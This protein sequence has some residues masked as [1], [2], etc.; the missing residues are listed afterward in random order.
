MVPEPVA[1]MLT[2]D[3]LEMH[4]LGH[5]LRSTKL[6][7]AFQQSP[8]VN[9]LQVGDKHWPI[10]LASILMRCPHIHLSLTKNSYSQL[11]SAHLLH[12]YHLLS[13]LLNTNTNTGLLSPS[14][15]LYPSAQKPQ[16]CPFPYRTVTARFL[17]RCLVHLP[18]ALMAVSK[19][20]WAPKFL[21]LCWFRSLRHWY[22]QRF[23]TIRL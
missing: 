11:C 4:D 10:G 3:L 15:S 19:T 21:F 1:P 8:Q 12:E 23:S 6:Y 16:H 13:R 9:H 20:K 22:H 2:G 17:M 7:F 18:V 14:I 5:H